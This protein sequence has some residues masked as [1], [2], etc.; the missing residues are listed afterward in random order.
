MTGLFNLGVAGGIAVACNCAVNCFYMISGY[1]I[2][3]TEEIKKIPKRVLKVWIPT[4]SYSVMI[5]ILLQLFGRIHLTIKEDLFLFIPFMSN[6]YWFSTCFIAMAVL[7]PFISKLLVV[8]SKG[9]LQF[10]I[11]SLVLLDCIQPVLGMNAFSNI[12]YGVMHAMTMY[13]IGYYLKQYPLKMKT[14]V[15]GLTFIT[16]VGIIGVIT[17]LSIKFTGDRN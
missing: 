6:Q 9:E 2:N 12:G 7:L 3:G 14:W 13:V 4:L 17:I 5:P 11:L 15:Y 10:L 16:C 8:L 1:M